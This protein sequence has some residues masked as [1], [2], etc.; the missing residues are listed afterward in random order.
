MSD[1]APEEL[2][3]ADH[4]FFR[5]MDPEFLARLTEKA[6]ART[7]EA[8]AL[9]VRE[10]DPA[11]EFLALFSG[12]VALEIIV[13]DRPRTT[14]QTLGPGEVLGWSWLFSPHRWRID[15][16]AV[17][18]TRALG[19]A[20]GPLR[21]LLDD[22]PADGYRFLHRLLPVIAQRLENTRLQLLDL[23]GR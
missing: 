16:R 19:L 8:G 4:R 3:L 9:I 18:P 17:K 5:D 11:D 2:R 21:Q 13:P 22:R 7:F 15:A 10:G 20:A 1:E 6:Y 12:K 23:H 14:V